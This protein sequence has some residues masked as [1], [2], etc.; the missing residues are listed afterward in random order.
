MANIDY[1]RTYGYWAHRNQLYADDPFSVHLND[2][3]Y[4]LKECGFD[5]K[6]HASLLGAAFLHDVLEDTE[7]T[8]QELE[9]KFGI[10]IV[11]LVWAVTGDRETRAERNQ[12]IYS[13]LLEVPTAKDLKVADRI[14]NLESAKYRGLDNYLSMYRREHEEFLLAVQGAHPALLERLEKAIS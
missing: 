8:F 1:C 10:A 13:R 11:S 2:V 4:V 6:E 5:E 9:E 12:C 14:A 7:T 3:F